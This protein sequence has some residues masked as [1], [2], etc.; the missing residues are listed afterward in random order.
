MANELDD[1]KRALRILLIWRGD[2]DEVDEAIRNLEQRIQ[3][4]I[5]EAA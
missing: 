1:L 4:L 2:S 5:E 3:I